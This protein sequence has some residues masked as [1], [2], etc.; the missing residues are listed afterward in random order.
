MGAGFVPQ[1]RARA[2]NIVVDQV[3]AEVCVTAILR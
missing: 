1:A 3:L 2:D